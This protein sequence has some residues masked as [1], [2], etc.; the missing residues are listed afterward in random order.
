MR[1]QL[2]S[3]V[4]ALVGS[5]DLDE[6]LNG[7][8]RWSIPELSDWS[9]VD[10]IADNRIRRTYLAHRDPSRAGLAAALQRFSPGWRWQRSWPELVAGRSVLNTEVTDEMLRAQA[11]SPEHLELMRQVGVRST[12]LVP[13]TARG[14]TAA[15]LVFVTT[16]ESQ[17]EYGPQDLEL[18]EELAQRAGIII[19]NA[20]LHQDL[21]S[22]AERFRIALAAVKIGVYEQD[23]DLRYR[24]H[25]NTA[26]EEDL[27]G[28]T[29]LDVFPEEEAAELTAIKRR[30]L[31]TGERVRGEV[32]LTIRGQ[33][34]HYRAAMDPLRDKSGA[35]VGLI[36]AATD[37]TDEKRVQNEL[38][39][40]V[41]FREQLMGVLGHDLRNPLSA[42]AMT[43]SAMR[44]TELSDIMR[45]QIDRIDH[46]VK[47][48]GEMIETLLDVTRTRFGD[49]LRISETE[50]DLGRVSRDMVDELRSAHPDRAIEL[51]VRGDLRGR[52]DGA[53]LE[54]VLSNLIG[55]ALAHGAADQPV[56]VSIDGGA[57]P[58]MLTVHNRGE[59][60][61]P[62]LQTVIFEPFRRGGGSPA[63]GLG[64]GLYIVE[65]I[66]RAH[67]GTV[68]VHSSAEAGT[69]FT[70]RLPRG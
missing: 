59:P 38:A 46:A 66:V 49:G 44:H 7:V 16:D 42:I 68:T 27:T 35:I 5:L 28:K 56:A 33:R 48:M 25:Y 18:A 11:R 24:W 22:T 17:R 54:E 3:K 26:F 31:E 45:K 60:I 41:S 50:V 9:L 23:T 70:V 62:D 2:L 36:G 20:R 61:A 69:S 65:Q 52:W 30:V 12:M 53:R 13:L 15:V 29:H 32:D 8:A 6:V 37:I 43:V 21:K 1:L 64:L 14:A 19:Q 58:V 51:V 47:R 39:Q 10:L 40:A 34:L 67:R 63:R 4:S 55:N 57:D